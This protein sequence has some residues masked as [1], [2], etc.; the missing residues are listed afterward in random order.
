LALFIKLLAGEF[1]FKNLV[2]KLVARIK[3]GW[4]RFRRGK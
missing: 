3:H 4:Q 2:K 1:Q